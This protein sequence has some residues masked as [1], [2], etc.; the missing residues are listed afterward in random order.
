MRNLREVFEEHGYSTQRAIAQALH[1][2]GYFPRSKLDSVRAYLN[3][4][5]KKRRPASKNL[6]RGLN[7]LTKDDIR[8]TAF[9]QPAQKSEVSLYI[10]L[11]SLCREIEERFADGDMQNKLEILLSLSKIIREK[12]SK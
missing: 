12:P 3:Q 9:F 10:S 8:I 4:V 1:E 2:G 11:E 6:I 7:E 5:I